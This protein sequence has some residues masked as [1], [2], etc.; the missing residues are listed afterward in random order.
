MPDET[1]SSTPSANGRGRYYQKAGGGTSVSQLGAVVLAKLAADISPGC[2]CDMK[3]GSRVF[4]EIMPSSATHFDGNEVGFEPDGFHLLEAARPVVPRSAIFPSFTSQSDHDPS[5]CEVVPPPPTNGRKKS[6]VT[7]TLERLELLR[8]QVLEGKM[9][10][11][12]HESRPGKLW[13]N[14]LARLLGCKREDL[15]NPKVRKVIGGMVEQFGAHIPKR[16][17]YS[18]AIT[19][20]ELEKLR[21]SQRKRE[22]KGEEERSEKSA[23]QCAAALANTR[24]ALEKLKAKCDKFEQARES[25]NLMLDLSDA[26]EV[27]GAKKLRQELQKCCQLLDEI[28]ANGGHPLDVADM[29]Q[30]AMDRKGVKDANV[31]RDL[32]FQRRYIWGL[33]TGDSPP[34]LWDFE[35]HAKLERYLNLPKNEI[36]TRA[37]RLRRGVGAIPMHLYPPEF[38]GKKNRTR[39]E[40]LKHLTPEDVVED[41]SQRHTNMR[42]IADELERQSEY[43][44]VLNKQRAIPYRWGEDDW[45]CSE[46]NPEWE[47]YERFRTADIIDYHLKRAGGRPREKTLLMH[48][49]FYS[50]LFGTWSAE[51]N[52]RFTMDPRDVSFA[53]LLFPN[54]LHIRLEVAS[55]WS[56]ECGGGAT[57]PVTDIQ[58]LV[59]VRALLHPKTG[60]L[61][62]SPELAAKLKPVIGKDGNVIVSQQQIDEVRANWCQACERAR[63]EYADLRSSYLKSCKR[64]RDSHE[65]ILEILKLDNP[66]IAFQMLCSGLQRE[67]IV[68]QSYG[69][70]CLIRDQVLIGILTQCAFRR[71]TLAKLD[72]KHLEYDEGRKGWVL[73]VP[74]RHFKNERGPYFVSPNGEVRDYSRFLV[75]CYGLYDAIEAYRNWAR[76]VVLA[77]SETAA[78]LACAPRRKRK[79]RALKQEVESGRFLG[80]SIRS[81]VYRLTARHV[82]HKPKTGE[83]IK[84]ITRF[85]PHAF[86]H[87][88]A[89]AILKASKAANPWQEAAD[90]IHDSE[91]TVRKN[92]ARYVPRDREDQLMATLQTVLSAAA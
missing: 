28:E 60:F 6:S 41:E 4:N 23:Q 62:Q 87:I 49:Q 82:G 75:D 9:F 78:L 59:D 29:I 35:R 22:L 66:L 19:V 48:R 61:T 31:V 15:R 90:A 12:S 76:S 8:E 44:K 40:M 1:P 56:A 33:R 58:R 18:G 55:A 52:H 85:S 2:A 79:S 72:L 24:W 36:L 17:T 77:G 69:H 83:G 89:T 5:G 47:A 26:G 57:L 70:A 38:R 88:L 73:R 27:S 80:A 50:A 13:Y 81:L 65:P 42:R 3:I 11:P 74:R 39:F 14:Q 46:A 16:E 54:L 68:Q 84:G 10:L 63:E 91:D 45:R 32:G 67:P 37:C 86:R 53:Y 30:L 25:I 92:Y 51:K 20:G 43:N 64:K 7:S 34:S 71:E 21:I